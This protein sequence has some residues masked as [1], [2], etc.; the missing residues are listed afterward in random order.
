M[1]RVALL[2]LPCLLV[3]TTP[4]P[5]ATRTYT[6]HQLHEA[7]P[8]VGSVESAITVPDAG[9]VSFVA[10]GVRIVHPRDSDLSLSLVSPGG[11]EVALSTK[12]GGG[13]ANFGDGPKGCSGGLTWFESAGGLDPISTGSAPFSDFYAPEQ[14][15]RRFEGREARGNWRLR[16]TDDTPGAAGVLLCWQLELSRSIVEHVRLSR[17]PVAAD[18]SFRESDSTYSDIRISIRRRGHL[19]LS[20]SLSRLVCRTC[21]ASGV[22][23]VLN[24]P[25]AISDLEGDG[26]PEVILNVFTGGAHCCLYTIFFRFDGRGYRSIAHDWGDLPGYGLADLDRDGRPELVSSD[27]RFSYAFT[28]YASSV[29]PAQIWHYDRGRLFDVTSSYPSTIRSDAGHIWR[30]YLGERKDRTSD[31]RGLLAAWLADEYRLGRGAEGWQRIRTALRRGELSA[32]RVDPLWPAG[33][34]YLS[35]LRSF[36]VKTGYAPS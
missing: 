33:R 10:V 4:A 6:S 15:L 30:E 19:A 7:I 31:L 18:L 36:L 22:D 17:G 24:D 26:E 5:A 28:A 3:L 1:R 21:P 25:L 32:P 35:A 20:A 12:E 9:P 8:D 29:R 14:S 23:A 13:G 16:M 11:V 34:K 27:D 2:C